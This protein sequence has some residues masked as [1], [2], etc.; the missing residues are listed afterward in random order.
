MWANQ[1]SKSEALLNFVAF[2][3]AETP[4][5]ILVVQPTL[6]MPE[7]FSKD[8]VSPQFRD[9]PILKGKIADPIFGE[10][11]PCVQEASRRSSGHTRHNNRFVVQARH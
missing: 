3:I 8:R 6:L 1:M 2:V 11:P 5:P 9:M 7:A 10:E 4:G